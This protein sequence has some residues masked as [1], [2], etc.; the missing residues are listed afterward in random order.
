MKRLFTTFSLLLALLTAS[1]Q[2]LLTNLDA[3]SSSYELFFLDEFNTYATA[4]DMLHGANATWHSGHTWMS[5]GSP[6]QRIKYGWGF[7]SGISYDSICA[8]IHPN[9]AFCYA[10]DDIVLQ[11]DPTEPGDKVLALNYTYHQTPI[12]PTGAAPEVRFNKTSGLIELND[13][14]EY[15]IYEIRCKVPSLDGLQAAFWIWGGQGEIDGF[16][17]IYVNHRRIRDFFNTIQPNL[18]TAYEWITDPSQQYHTYQLA[19][20]PIRIS[21]FIDGR[22]VRTDTRKLIAGKL[23]FVLSAHYMWSCAGPKGANDYCQTRY[24][25]QPNDP[26]LIDYVKIYKPKP[27]SVSASNEWPAYQTMQGWT[28]FRVT[29]M[30]E[31][32]PFIP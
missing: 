27:G 20:T 2:G 17:T 15:G 5:A 25:K 8:D 28:D 29:T 24:C 9:K 16:E 22:E 23:N 14:T 1:A 6:M 7:R 12:T 21:W 4:F 18:T 3:S 30:A 31:T 19:W 13:P 11:N 26:F 10:E 32:T